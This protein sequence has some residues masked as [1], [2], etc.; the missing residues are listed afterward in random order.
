MKQP[1]FAFVSKTVHPL[2]SEQVPATKQEAKEFMA[3]LGWDY[4]QNGDDPYGGCLVGIPSEVE[5]ELL[6]EGEI[7]RKSACGRFTVTI[8]A[9]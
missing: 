7:S 2:D 3:E 4:M 9:D 5:T 1:W 8:T 6:A